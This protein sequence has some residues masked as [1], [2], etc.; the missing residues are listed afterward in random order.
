MGHKSVVRCAVLYKALCIVLKAAID[1]AR[2]PCVNA[3][4]SQTPVLDTD[5]GGALC[6]AMRVCK[7][8]LK[9]RQ[10]EV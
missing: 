6:G 4:E 9:D 10:M 1:A 7:T 8:W 5:T 2:M 3:G